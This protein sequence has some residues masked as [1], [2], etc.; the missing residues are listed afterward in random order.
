MASHINTRTVA[1][2][3]KMMSQ[4]QYMVEHP[5]MQQRNWVSLGKEW[6]PILGQAKED[7]QREVEQ[8]D[9]ILDSHHA[10]L[11]ALEAVGLVIEKRDTTS[12]GYRW[13]A[14]DLE[15]AFPTQ[16]AA[17]EAGLRARLG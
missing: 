9:F 6:L 11:G 16:A 14:G 13:H 10:L 8:N 15:G 7:L 4:M 3:E 2:I 12:W 17:A 1:A 5:R